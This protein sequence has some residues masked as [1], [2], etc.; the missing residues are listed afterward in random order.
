MTA[1]LPGPGAGRPPAPQETATYT[2]DMAPTTGTHRRLGTTARRLV[3]EVSAFGIVG[4][5][6]F[7]LDIALFQL[8]YATLGVGAVTSKLVATVISMTAAY[9]AHRYWSFSHRARTNVRRE[10]LL[11]AVINGSALLLGLLVVATV[12]YPLGQDSAIVLQTANIASI[13]LS[14]VL[15]FLAYRRWVF[16]AHEEPE[17]SSATSADAR[18]VA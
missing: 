12:R 1:T 13:V 8:L 6:C 9:F 18:I 15:R 5:A 7:F 3:K 10:Y 2:P 14:T 17:P 11:F 16:P 4:A